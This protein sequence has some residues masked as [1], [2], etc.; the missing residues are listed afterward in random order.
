MTAALSLVVFLVV[1]VGLIALGSRFWRRRE[2]EVE[3]GLDL[4]PYLLLALAVGVAGFSAAGLA[5]ASLTSNQFAGTPTGELSAA[6]AGL[7]VAAPISYFLWRRQARRRKVFP[8]TAGWPVYLAV[9]EAV[10]L[11][12]FLVSVGQLADAF[13][14]RA[15]TARWTDLIVYGGLVGFHWW[16]ERREQPHGDAG[17]LP[18]IVGS[19]VAL[20]ALTVG[21]IGTLAW[22]LAEA[23]QAIGGAIDVPEPQ[24]PLA[25]TVVAV[26]IWAWRWMPPWREESTV[27]R[28]LY[29]SVVTSIALTIAFGAGVTIATVLIAFLLG[30]GGPA[31]THFDVYPA[32]I[33]FALVGSAIWLHHRRRLGSGRT[34]ALRGYEYAM[35]AVGLASL[36]ASVVGLINAVLEPQLAGSN[37][38]EVLIALGCTV[39]A[40]GAVWLWFWRKAQAAPR[41]EEIHVFQRRL[42]LIG[43]SVATGL[44]A[45]GALIGSLVV[46]F[47]ALL[48]EGGEISDSLPLPL[49]LAVVSGL[50]FWHLFDQLRRDGAG[51]K[52]LEV[53]PFTVT[54]IC[55][56]P[57]GL[58]AMFPKEAR[59]RVIYRADGAGVIDDEMASAI[60]STVANTSSIVWVDDTGFEVAPAREP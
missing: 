52:R 36:I 35:A 44:T 18:R 40:S 42:Y 37:T 3:G 39:I 12:A 16:A 28:N 53:K 25:L 32:A 14:D 2:D 38:G 31:A 7:V 56:H 26:P 41:E 10:F 49:S 24:I 11:T 20:I 15:V 54:V 45:A 50:A 5:R 17:E 57:G 48:G 8:E 21:T 23:Y 27:F 51:L 58:T 1:V 34:G 60:V 47:R 4:I 46:V 30:E 33:S 22:L 59:T 55:S 43:M 19:G 9:I 13:T 6:L 29:L